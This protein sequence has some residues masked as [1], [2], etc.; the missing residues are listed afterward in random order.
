MVVEPYLIDVDEQAVYDLRSRI[1]ATRW[2]DEIP[3]TGWEYG[4][5]VSYLR[6]L[7]RY[8]ETE[9]DW[10]ARQAALNA[11]PQFVARL[12]AGTLHFVH[13]RAAQQPAPVLVLVHGWPGAFVQMLPLCAELDDFDIVMPALPGFPCSDR[14]A[15][16]G[17][18]VRAM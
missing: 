15:R 3:G 12:P 14:P 16:A 18:G 17:V 8:W 2:P 10:A 1:R 4:T 7:G 11:L 6:D 13:R 9:F 5:D